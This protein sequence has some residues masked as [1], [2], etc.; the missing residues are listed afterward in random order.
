MSLDKAITHGKER[1]KPY[2]GE[3]AVDPHCRNHPKC[4]W[5][6]MAVEYKRKKEQ[7]SD[8]PAK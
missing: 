4:P 1:R 7:P 3:K 2:Y 5:C 8:R 6:R